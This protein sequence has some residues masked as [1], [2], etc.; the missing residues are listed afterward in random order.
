MNEVR[1]IVAR[2]ICCG[3]SGVCKASH[4]I[5]DS[6]GGSVPVCGVVSW[7]KEAGDV[8]AAL[9]AKGWVVVNMGDLSKALEDDS[10]LDRLLSD[11]QSISEKES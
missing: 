7:R 1:E 10:E 9:I 4:Q 5:Y 8:I 2:A 3:A 6:I 11:D